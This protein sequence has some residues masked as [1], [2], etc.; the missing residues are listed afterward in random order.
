[1]LCWWLP[2]RNSF[3]VIFPS[4]IKVYLALHEAAILINV[5]YAWVILV[6][7]SSFIRINFHY[8]IIYAHISPIMLGFGLY[9][10]LIADL[11]ISSQVLGEKHED[12]AKLSQES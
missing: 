7:G 4:R 1:M 11:H 3:F 9:V 8:F 2:P 12:K 10:F 6:F 5:I